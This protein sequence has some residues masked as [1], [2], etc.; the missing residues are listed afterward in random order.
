[1]TRENKLALIIGFGLI[2]VVGILVSDHFSTA[3]RQ[4]SVNLSN[5]GDLTIE[6]RLDDPA[7]LTPVYSRES[8]ANDE[9]PRNRVIDDLPIQTPDQDTFIIENDIAQH[10]LPREE[11]PTE[12]DVITMPGQDALVAQ[13]GPRETVTPPV[14]PQSY[15]WYTIQRGESLAKIARRKYG[16]EKL[17]RKLALFNQDRIPNPDVVPAGVTIRLPSK[18]E[19]LG[20]QTM[21]AATSDNNNSSITP[22][23][24]KQQT[25]DY[26]KYTVKKG[27]VLSEIALQ[28]M[29][30]SKK[31][32][33]I[34]EANKDVIKN[35]DNVPAGTT[36]RI[37]TS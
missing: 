25:G 19:L 10:E 26:K 33:T 36:I 16:D 31:W 18:E 27:D 20:N 22:D 5:E 9:L 24:A 3:N 11:V 2:L 1:M 21:V 8:P 35:P 14:L 15:S 7:F 37:P 32:R 28:H 12:V 17:W 13:D 34:Y 30:S 23:S 4:G 29:G 6:D